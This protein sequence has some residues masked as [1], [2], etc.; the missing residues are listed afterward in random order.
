MLDLV[1]GIPNDFSLL[2]LDVRSALCMG[3]TVGLHQKIDRLKEMG[4]REARFMQYV[5][6]NPLLKG[7][8]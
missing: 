1:S 2:A 3:N 6:S 5:S 4:Y 8:Q 7:K